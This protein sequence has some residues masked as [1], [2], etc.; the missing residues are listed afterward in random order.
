MSAPPVLIIRR[1]TKPEG[2]KASNAVSTNPAEFRYQVKDETALASSQTAS[3]GHLPWILHA[4][5]TLLSSSRAY[6]ISQPRNP[7]ITQDV[8]NVFITVYSTIPKRNLFPRTTK[9]QRWH[10][11]IVLKTQ[12]LWCC[13]IS[14]AELC[15]G[16]DN[17]KKVTCP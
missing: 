4:L 8:F 13:Q 6:N 2:Y 11:T 7:K 14:P 9:N 15:T 5:M 3:L 17:W 1:A 12:Y 10:L 16:K